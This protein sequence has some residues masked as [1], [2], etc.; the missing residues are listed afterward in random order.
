MMPQILPKK[1]KEKMMPK[2]NVSDQSGTFC[3][4]WL[5]FL[6]LM[7]I[8]ILCSPGFLNVDDDEVDE[9]NEHLSDVEDSQLLDNSGW[10]SRTRFVFF[11]EK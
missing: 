4:V 2:I 5:I 11:E 1:K 9:D 7:H 6:D 8:F 3:T 10:S